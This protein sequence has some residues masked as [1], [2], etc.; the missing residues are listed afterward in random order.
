MGVTFF[1]PSVRGFL[2][3]TSAS[4]VVPVFMF[5]TTST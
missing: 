4:S 3:G 2:S 5:D 1:T